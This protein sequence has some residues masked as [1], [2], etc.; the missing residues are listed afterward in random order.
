M[1]I[2]VCVETR[3][4][5]IEPVS[6]ELLSAA[7]AL[8][9]AGQGSVEAFTLGIEPSVAGPQLAFVDTLVSVTGTSAYTPEAYG[10]AVLAAVRQ[11]KPNIVLARSLPP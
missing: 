11:R 5:R 2:L 10:A 6:L 8:A 7:H 1:K 3:A 4:A 9:G